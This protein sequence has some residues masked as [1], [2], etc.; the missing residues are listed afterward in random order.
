M[1]KAG[2]QLTDWNRELGIYV[3][4]RALSKRGK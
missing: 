1:N 2:F 3:A 4:D